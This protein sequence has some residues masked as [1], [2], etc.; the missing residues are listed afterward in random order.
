MILIEIARNV[1]CGKVLDSAIC[2]CCASG[3][4]QERAR[5]REIRKR[6][7]LVL[8]TGLR[9]NC[10]QVV[11]FKIFERV[12]FALHLKS[13]KNAVFEKRTERIFAIDQTLK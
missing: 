13:T 12:A 9:L 2:M 11:D 3:R 10:F 4:P 6:I 8:L 1:N 5:K 7:I